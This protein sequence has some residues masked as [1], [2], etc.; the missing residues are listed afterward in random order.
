MAEKGI[1]QKFPKNIIKKAFGL[2]AKHRDSLVIVNT[3]TFSSL[4]NPS[5]LEIPKLVQLQRV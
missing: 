4:V 5:S 3:H 2:A 1:S